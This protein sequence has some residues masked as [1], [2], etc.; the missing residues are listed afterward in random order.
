M[1]DFNKW[2]VDNTIKYG[3]NSFFYKG[4]MYTKYE[5]MEVFLNDKKP[6]ILFIRCS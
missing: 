2:M 1:T 5:L 4:R 6:L 3:N